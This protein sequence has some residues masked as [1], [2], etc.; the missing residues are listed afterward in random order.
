[1]SKKAM[2]RMNKSFKESFSEAVDNL[3]AKTMGDEAYKAEVEAEIEAEE[4]AKQEP[5]KQPA[6]KVEQPAAPQPAD[7]TPEQQPAAPE[8]EQAQQPE[9][10]E[11]PTPAESA[12]S[13][14]QI[15]DDA[16]DQPLPET[17]PEEVTADKIN[18][19][20]EEEIMESTNT[21]SKVRTLQFYQELG[22]KAY[23][24]ANGLADLSVY[25][26]LKDLAV[27]LVMKDE[28]ARRE[29]AV[30]TL[31]ADDQFR[32]DA[33]VSVVPSYIAGDSKCRD[34]IRGMLRDHETSF[35]PFVHLYRYTVA[36]ADGSHEAWM[37][38]ANAEKA[39]APVLATYHTSFENMIEEVFRIKN[40]DGTLGNE[41]SVAAV[42]GYIKSCDPEAQKI[43]REKLE[44][45]EKKV[46]KKPA[47][48]KAQPAKAD[49]K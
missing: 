33:V 31:N 35:V 16:A 5:K 30:E 27:E 43:L 22:N 44:L 23:E 19:A 20:K 8:A 42:E 7:N 17:R 6:E 28:D 24:V 2:K 29:I 38:R 18:D 11:E 9:Q 39:I 41:V 45:P 15:T 37:S 10:A 36:N 21:T 46:E 34:K 4:E 25:P 13:P 32:A 40:P 12:E 49:K 1:M 3:V 48:K 14:E 47:P 26:E